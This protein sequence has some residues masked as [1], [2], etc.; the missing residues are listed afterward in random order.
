MKIP[1]GGILFI[2]K[3]ALGGDSQYMILL[4]L[5]L[6][7]LNMDAHAFSTSAQPQ[8]YYHRSLDKRILYKT[9]YQLWAVLGL[10][11]KKSKLP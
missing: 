6:E 8:I 7:F 2:V 10:Q 11:R 4:A 1:V 3:T 9:N 5:Y